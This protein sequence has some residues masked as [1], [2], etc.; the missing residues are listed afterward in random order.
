MKLLKV[1]FF[2]I[3][4][5]TV[6]TPYV[7]SM[8]QTGDLTEN[9]TET[10]AKQNLCI[11]CEGITEDRKIIP[12]ICCNADMCRLCVRKILMDNNAL[13]DLTNKSR[14]VN[15]IKCPFCTNPLFGDDADF[16]Q[17]I[18]GNAYRKAFH[19]TKKRVAKSLALEEK[20][21]EEDNADAALATYQDDVEKYND[22]TEILIAQL[23]AQDELDETL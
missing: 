19:R 20:Q 6:Q 9:S 10:E 4:T 17:T 12:L 8:E 1:L 7:S 3:L 21:A 18:R 2:V 22:A 11:L 15:N 23:L 13:Q 16:L 5:A 14:Q